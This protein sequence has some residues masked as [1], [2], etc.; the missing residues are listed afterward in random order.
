MISDLFV[1]GI[2]I[3]QKTESDGL[4]VKNIKKLKIKKELRI[5]KSIEKI[6]M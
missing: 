4:L 6:Q 5:L 2:A 1:S 3:F